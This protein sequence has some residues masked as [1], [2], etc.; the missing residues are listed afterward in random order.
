VAY[1]DIPVGKKKVR[2]RSTPAKTSMYPDPP[3]NIKIIIKPE[4]DEL[5][6]QEWL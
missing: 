4:S 3:E 5:T 2:I 6:F 1:Y